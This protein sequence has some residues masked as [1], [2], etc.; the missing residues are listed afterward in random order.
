MGVKYAVLKSPKTKQKDHYVFCIE[1]S[2]NKTTERSLLTS[3]HSISLHQYFILS[4]SFSIFT[5]YAFFNG[6][7]IAKSSD[8][9]FGF[10]FMNISHDLV[11]TRQTMHTLYIVCLTYIFILKCL[12]KNPLKT[13]WRT[14]MYYTFQRAAI[15]L[16]QLKLLG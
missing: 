8:L 1:V 3:V 4:R 14:S 16:K 10:H 6:S 2:Q 12:A 15:A 11:G 13:N 7:I 5:S 9:I